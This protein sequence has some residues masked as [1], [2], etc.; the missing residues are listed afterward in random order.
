MHMGLCAVTL[1]WIFFPFC[2]KIQIIILSG[3]LINM[4]GLV[5][6]ELNRPNASLTALFDL[7]I[8]HVNSL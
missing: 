7:I 3:L 8:S 5:I 1:S 6:K 4:S 2:V